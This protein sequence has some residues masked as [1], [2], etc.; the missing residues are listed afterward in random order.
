MA[1]QEVESGK[2]QVEWTKGELERC[3]VEFNAYRKQKVNLFGSRLRIKL[4]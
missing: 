1:R 4:M 3:L 2:K